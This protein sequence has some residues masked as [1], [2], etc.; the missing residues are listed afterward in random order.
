MLYLGLS[1]CLLWA[2]TKAGVISVTQFMEGVVSIPFRLVSACRPRTPPRGALARRRGTAGLLRLLWEQAGGGAG[3]CGVWAY[4]RYSPGAAAPS[5]GE[6]PLARRGGVKGRCP[7]SWPPASHRL[8]G[9]RGE[10][11]GGRAGVPRRPPPVPWL[12]FLAAAGGWLEDPGPGPSYS[13][14]RGVACPPLLRAPP[15]LF[16]FPGR[17][18]WPGWLLVGQFRPS[19]PLTCRAGGQGGGGLSV[20]PSLGGVVGG[21]R[22]ARGGG[23]LCLSLSPCFRQMGNKAG[24]IGFAQSMEGMV[25]KLLRLVSACCRPDVVRGLPLR[26]SAGL[27]AC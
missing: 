1:F 16:G 21:R 11:E 26:A 4:L 12:G 10:R 6:P 5:G 20:P 24:F 22:G 27:Q 8:G 13:R 19:R 7:L 9:E 2:G 23:L 17:G 15:K 25:S 14:L 18:A 3:A